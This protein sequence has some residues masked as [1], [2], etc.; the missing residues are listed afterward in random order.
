MVNSYI[1]RFFYVL[2]CLTLTSC[3]I[4]DAYLQTKFDPNEYNL[5][6]K[7]RYKSQLAK[8]QCENYQTSQA[9]AAIIFSDSEYFV[10]YSQYIPRN[11]DLIDAVKNLNE[12]V[13]GLNDQ[14][15]KNE[16]VSLMF[17]RIKFEDIEQTAEK[18]QQIIAG[19]PR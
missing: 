3:T 5:I 6:S 10:L 17:C 8:T 19:R 16:K 15:I 9:N 13:K 12:M 14:Y 1:K 11:Q 18:L 7:I 4:V 2:I